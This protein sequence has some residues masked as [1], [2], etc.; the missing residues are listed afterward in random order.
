MK[1][2]SSN[3]QFG[4][5]PKLEHLN[6]PLLLR[7]AYKQ[8]LKVTIWGLRDPSMEKVCYSLAALVLMGIKEVTAGGTAVYYWCQLVNS[9]LSADEKSQHIWTSIR[10]RADDLQNII[11][12][13]DSMMN[14]LCYYLVGYLQ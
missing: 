11:Y 13:Y 7:G 14:N 10:A 1:H 6:A 5:I 3:L 9:L 12:E 8:P 4:I 2:K